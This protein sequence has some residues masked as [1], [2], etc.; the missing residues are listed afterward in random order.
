VYTL[1]NA[2]GDCDARFWIPL[3][4]CGWGWQTLGVQYFWILLCRGV[5]RRKRPMAIVCDHSRVLNWIGGDRRSLAPAFSGPNL[6]LT[7]Y[8]YYTY[9]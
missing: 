7:L 6:M 3:S 8:I 4:R 5:D 9:S 2:F 1:V